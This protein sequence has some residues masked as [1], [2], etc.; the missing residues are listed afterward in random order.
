MLAALYDS[1][2]TPRRL[3]WR[4]SV[5]IGPASLAPHS[6]G[7]WLLR[8]PRRHSPAALDVGALVPPPDVDPISLQVSYVPPWHSRAI[9]RRCPDADHVFFSDDDT[10]KGMNQQTITEARSYCK[11]CPVARQCLTW[12]L[13]TPERAGVW[14]GTTWY[15]RQRLLVRAAAGVSIEQLVDECLGA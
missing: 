9:C 15:Q 11:V 8:A 7:V 1:P 13:T 5:R 10:R 12:A 6:P 3:H 4:P 14:G 2:P